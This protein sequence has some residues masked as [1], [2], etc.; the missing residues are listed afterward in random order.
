MSV[1]KIL[2][3]HTINKIA[4]GEVVER[5]FSVVKELVENSIDAKASSIT[6]EIKNGG[7][8]FIRITDN[9]IGIPKEEVEIAFLRHA[10]SKIKTSDDLI[11][12]LTLGFR[13]EALASIASI[14]HVE[15]I[16]K[17]SED[18]TGK[19]VEVA[20]GKITSSE[21]IACPNG[22]T[23]II[24]HIFY[25]VPARKEFLGNSSV[26][27]AKISDYM[28]RLALGHPEISFKYIQNNKMQFTTSGNHDLVNCV[29]NLY[30][31]DIAKNTSKL[32]Y[33]DQGIECVGLLGK[34]SLTRAN[35]NY[36]HF[37][38]NGRY[39]KST[40]LQRA[41][42]SAYKT[43]VMVGKFPF[44][45]LHLRLDPKQVDVNVHPTKMQVRFKD[46]ELIYNTVYQGIVSSLKEENLVP[47]VVPKQ[48]NASSTTSSFKSSPSHEQIVVDTFFA[49]RKNHNTPTAAT[50][51][52]RPT[53]SMPF[54]EEKKELS[55]KKEEK[56]FGKV[57]EKETLIVSEATEYTVVPDYTII[58]QLFQTYWVIQ[59]DEKIFIID[60]HAAHERVMYEKFMLSFKKGS[61]ATQVL[62]LPETFTITY[63]EQVIMNHHDALF[64]KLGFKYEFF[65]EN[66][67]VVREVPFIFNN[68]LPARTFKH[69]LDTLSVDKPQDITSLKED[70]IIRLAC[71]SAIK[72]NDKISE[73]ECKYLIEELLKLD[74]PFTC[75]HGRP[76]LVALAKSDIEKMFKR[77]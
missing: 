50:M 34:P 21:E 18:I 61:I 36:E 32:Y 5:P 15:L 77:I 42:E 28:T 70:T 11:K 74:N 19:R 46:E 24:R 40:L 9:G 8:D 1:I 66:S 64:S 65:G 17:T 37:F 69:V 38:I 57:Q 60:Q 10:T 59:Y 52:A 4:A 49:P 53:S 68:P 56:L 25:N 45:I 7:I 72:A 62:L 29:L 20:G 33:K 6:V 54:V 30:G 48:A 71:R 43:L 39:I 16:T 75:P 2:D 63:S 58:G 27:G 14:S 12:V 3:T 22:T 44:I 31:K 55:Y 76:T 13:G 26:E 35:R 41:V 67:I 51:L 73:R 23:L 47:Q